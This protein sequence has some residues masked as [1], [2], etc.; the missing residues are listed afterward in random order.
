MG[1]KEMEVY[2]RAY[3]SAISIHRLSLTLPANEK[4]ELGSQIR[5][6]AF[7]ILLNISEGCGRNSK[8]ELRRFLE[9]SLGSANEVSVLLD[10][11]LT[12]GYLDDSKHNELSNSLRI[13][14]AQLTTWRKN[15]V[16]QGYGLNDTKSNNH[17]PP[18]AS[19]LQQE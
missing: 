1:Y 19:G 11:F 17:Q 16:A 9:I 2:K 10:V 6:A 3:S 4:Y 14:G 18:A 12:L 13:I 15:L 7:S 5:R 8:Q